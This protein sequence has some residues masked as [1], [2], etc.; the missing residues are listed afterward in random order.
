MPY[1]HTLWITHAKNLT[2]YLLHQA[3]S[4]CLNYPLLFEGHP[5]LVLHIQNDGEFTKSARCFCSSLTLLEEG[6]YFLPLRIW[7]NL[8]WISNALFF[9]TREKGAV[10]RQNTFQFNMYPVVESSLNIVLHKQ[11]E[12]SF[13]QLFAVRYD[14]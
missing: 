4:S 11:R 5:G 8:D 6:V 14:F 13:L 1:K 9:E 3:H 7:L 10:I 12:I 2:L